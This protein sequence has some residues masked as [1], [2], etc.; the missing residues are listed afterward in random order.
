MTVE[1][2]DIFWKTVQCTV[3][4][5][6]VRTDRCHPYFTGDGNPN[7][8]ILK[9][10]PRLN[11]V[12]RIEIYVKLRSCCFLKKI[13]VINDWYVAAWIK[14]CHVF[15]T[16]LNIIHPIIRSSVSV[17]NLAI[18]SC[19]PTWYVIYKLYILCSVVCFYLSCLDLKR[20]VFMVGCVRKCVRS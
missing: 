5:D 11:S 15:L 3:E 13:G 12:A 6:V 2:K 14:S 1:Q 20:F 19:N 18:F 9:Y 16:F 7:V 10:V 8:D 4:K 17:Q